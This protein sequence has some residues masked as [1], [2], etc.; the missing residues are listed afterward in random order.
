MIVI[1]F[2]EL[3]D[4]KQLLF[5]IDALFTISYANEWFKDPQV[6][7]IATEVDN[8]NHVK[9][10]LFECKQ[11]GT[12]GPENLSAG[13]KSL[14]L[15][16]KADLKGYYFKLSSLGDN[17]YSIL[18]K[19]GKMKNVSFFV[20]CVPRIKDGECDFIVEETGDKISS[21]LEIARRCALVW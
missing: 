3:K 4:S 5:D 16:L 10:N 12:F 17:C 9:D 13:A 6:I 8:V 2:D 1:R 21:S 20:D 19:I 11:Y 18:S 14:I 15:A 7:S